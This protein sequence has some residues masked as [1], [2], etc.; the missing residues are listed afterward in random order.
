MEADTLSVIG[1]FVIGAVFLFACLLA[2]PNLQDAISNSFGPAQIIDANFGNA[3]STVFL[4]VVSAATST[5]GWAGSGFAAR[6]RVAQLVVDLAR[7]SEPGCARDILAHARVGYLLKERVS[8]MAV[9]VDALH[10][11]GEGECVIERLW[12]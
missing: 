9:L 3:F 4:L 8:D 1:A 2:I 7:S 6:G 5:Y 12:T 11:I 10:R